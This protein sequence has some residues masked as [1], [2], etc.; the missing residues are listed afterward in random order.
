MLQRGAAPG[1]GGDADVPVRD[2]LILGGGYTGRRVAARLA[3]RGHRVTVTVRDAGRWAPLAG[4]RVVEM[5][6]GRTI[7]R[8]TRGGE[9]VLDSVPVL[10]GPWDGTRELLEAM[11]GDAARIVYLSTTGVYGRQREVDET[12]AAAPETEA[13]RL[14]VAAEEMVLG[15]RWSGMVLRPAAIYGPGRGAH[16]SIPA[17]RFRLL[18][19]GSN[20]VSRIHVDDLAA[21]AET[22]LLSELGGAWPVADDEPARSREVAEYVCGLLGCAMPEGAAGEELHETR[23]ANRRV[24]GRAVRRALGVEL[25]YPDYRAGIRAAIQA[26]YG[27]IHL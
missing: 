12:T 15:G 10:D 16:V 27:Y 17:G 25:R 7:P 4:V 3:A 11:G 22:A 5:A 19:D 20:Y 21:L 6:L 1:R 14:R 23:R 13:S 8:L 18:G 26:E 2:I 24:D 9:L